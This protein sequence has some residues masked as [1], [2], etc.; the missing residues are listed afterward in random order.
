MN[1]TVL[2]DT[3]LLIIRVGIGL[4][5]IF[6]HGFQKLTGG[7]ERWAGIGKTMSN[8]GI[9]FMPVFWGFMAAFAETFGAVFLILGLFYRPATFML[10]FTM[11]VAMMTHL[12]KLDPWN[13]VGYPMELMIVFI[14][15]LL[16]GPGRFS[17]DNML[18]GRKNK[19]QPAS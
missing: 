12:A 14:G 1:K 4:S 7:P 18:F 15:L 9:D 13:K 10:A 5:F 2:A 19:S 17:L 11:F 3:G 6:L 8:L 16:I